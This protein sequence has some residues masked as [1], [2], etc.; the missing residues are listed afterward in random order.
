MI[1]SLRWWYK[2]RLN[3]R[4]RYVHRWHW[5]WWRAWRARRV[6]GDRC[7]R[8]RCW[9]DLFSSCS[10]WF[11]TSRG[12]V[13]PVPGSIDPRSALGTLGDRLLHPDP[14]LLGVSCS[15]SG[16]L[17]NRSTSRTSWRSAMVKHV[18]LVDLPVTYEL[19]VVRSRLRRG[20]VV[21]RRCCSMSP[22]IRRHSP[23][24]LTWNRLLW[25]PRQ[26]PDA[27]CRPP[28]VFR[29]AHD[30]HGPEHTNI[31]A[32]QVLGSPHVES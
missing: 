7:W 29:L 19:P 15:L 11:C 21:R 30:R 24:S 1:A 3:Y 9:G 26:V 22:R 16:S 20:L 13:H 27:H 17:H 23:A 25:A 6:W 28:L 32:N 2:C 31:R 8:D 4:W 10:R 12:I 18:L 5:H 14:A